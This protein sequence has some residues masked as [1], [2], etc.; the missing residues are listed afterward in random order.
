MTHFLNKKRYRNGAGNGSHKAYK[1]NCLNR[2]DSVLN[3]GV[4]ALQGA[5]IEHSKILKQLGATVVEVRKPEQLTHLDGLI[6]P[7]GESTSIGLIAERWGLIE[8]LRE[9][10]QAGK[11]IWGICAGM[12]LLAERAEGQKA[13]GQP[14]LG[15]LDITVNRNYF[16]RQVDSFEMLL[17][18]PKIPAL[19]DG[20]ELCSAI[21]IRAPV[22]TAIGQGVEPLASLSAADGGKL[23]VAVRQGSILATAFH[24]ELTA[25]IRWHQLFLDMVCGQY[26]NPAPA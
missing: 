9:W 5:F 7:G 22:I 4:L 10:V 1:R 20:T 24:P 13:G 11:P 18:T 21:F 12:V 8:P 16:G 6:I 14:L 3:I 26:R 23:I 2:R 17:D 15:G 19:G 25:D